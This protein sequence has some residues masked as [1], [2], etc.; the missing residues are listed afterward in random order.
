MAQIVD[1]VAPRSYPLDQTVA[2]HVGLRQVIILKDADPEDRL[3]PV[4]NDE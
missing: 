1:E 4:Q 3:I 2:T